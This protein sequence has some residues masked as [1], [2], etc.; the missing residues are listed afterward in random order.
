M[1]SDLGKSA[2]AL[3]AQ[4]SLVQTEGELEVTSKDSF[5][6]SNQIAYLDLMNV[7]KEPLVCV[8]QQK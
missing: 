8:G 5:V 2:G 7:W 1:P 6:V 3:A 4:P